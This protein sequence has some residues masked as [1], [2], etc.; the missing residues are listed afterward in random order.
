MNLDLFF[1]GTLYLFIPDKRASSLE[2]LSL[3]GFLKE[4]VDIGEFRTSSRKARS[5]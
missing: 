1:I 3:E 4:L 2:I 5:S